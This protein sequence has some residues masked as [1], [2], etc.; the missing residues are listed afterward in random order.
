M[1]ERERDRL[2]NDAREAHT[3]GH[4]EV[5]A[6][7]CDQALQIA[8]GFG[9]AK[10]LRGMVAA[11]LGR[12]DVAIRHLREVAQADPS[13]YEAHFGLSAVYRSNGRLQE[14]IQEA[15]R[16]V[17]LRPEE[18][19]AHLN[20]GL[21]LFESSRLP[22]ALQSF[23]KAIELDPELGAAH[24][25]LGLVLQQ[26]GRREEAVTEFR[27]TLETSPNA[28]DTLFAL[29]QALLAGGDTKGAAECAKRALAINYRLAPALILLSNAFADENRMVEAEEA[30]QRAIALDPRSHYPQHA[31]AMLYQQM[32]RFDDAQRSLERSLTLQPRQGAAYFYM[33][34]IKKSCPEDSWLIGRMEDLLAQGGLPAADMALLHFGAGK[35]LEDIGEYEKAM[36]HFE[37]G[38]RATYTANYGN[39]PFN[40]ERFATGHN[41]IAELMT[42]EYLERH[43]DAGVQSELPIFICG[44][45][46]SGTTLAEQIVS[47]HPDV[48]G[49]GE[50]EFWIEN[51]WAAVDFNS[52]ELDAAKL[53]E[54]AERY[55]KL[56]GAIAP[57][58]AR[59][60]DKMPG[61]S[62]GLGLIHLALPQA[63]IIHLQRNP[64]DTCLS[65]FTTWF[66]RPPEFA[67]SKEDIVFAYQQYLNVMAHWRKVLP[68]D[69]FMDVPYEE[70]AA[71][72]QG[73]IRRMTSFC[74]LEWDDAC[75]YPDKNT[76]RVKT[77]SLW[78]V[79][80]PVNS[81]AV[82]RWRRYEPW[83]GAFRQLQS[84][85]Q[86][87][88]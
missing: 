26:L 34:Q 54:L 19:Q 86:Q 71:D 81:S 84:S 29:G 3:K 79:R 27:R 74:G 58:A 63:R 25:N 11:R 85:E 16:A 4:L 7:L 8:P 67:A 20:L 72:P 21:A 13:C 10:L 87:E 2:M 83:L 65:I 82:G 45:I 57:G 28:I 17:A 59:V 38:N 39:S 75:L 52:G 44:M 64:L 37:Q 1:S 76:R 32:G 60:T 18:P 55:L 5:A 9:P 31:L 51:R 43:R 50:L 40:R 48:G 24:H 66:K 22:D 73:V 23:E 6:N 30:A 46:R 35:A 88:I 15:K 12:A 61:N 80:N 14:S 42:A 56:L 33:S 49:G 78:Q 41:R 36:G 68:R 53:R 70:L 62:A 77:P 69:R 47:C